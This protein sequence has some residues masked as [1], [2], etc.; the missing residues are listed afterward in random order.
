MATTPG[1][2]PITEPHT[3]QDEAP[4]ET[5]TPAKVASCEVS[6]RDEVEAGKDEHQGD[7]STSSGSSHGITS[8]VPPLAISSTE[9]DSDSKDVKRTPRSRT[10]SLSTPRTPR[11][12]SKED[13]A[14][15]QESLNSLTDL[16]SHLHDDAT[17]DETAPIVSDNE[18]EST[19]TD[20]T[21]EE[22]LTPREDVIDDV[23]TPRDDA[24]VSSM[25]TDKPA[26]KETL[27]PGRKPHEV[28]DDV[29][30]E[31]DKHTSRT[32]SVHNESIQSE[33]LMAA[34]DMYAAELLH[35]QALGLE[36]R[37]PNAP[38]STD[39]THHTSQAVRVSSQITVTEHGPSDHDKSTTDDDSCL[40]ADPNQD[41]VFEVRTLITK[42]HATITSTSD[43]S[44]S[45]VTA[46]NK[47]PVFSSKAYQKPRSGPQSPFKPS[48][49]PFSSGRN[50]PYPAM[51][52]LSATSP[53]PSPL[54]T[55]AA[56][57]TET[58]DYEANLIKELEVFKTQAALMAHTK[59]NLEVSTHAPYIRSSPGLLITWPRKEPGHQQEWF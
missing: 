33:E 39:T 34:I 28:I 51:E 37:S 26:M 42:T 32:S 21:T 8:I 36:P 59:Q 22:A 19:P 46:T 13:S 9:E 27:S 49:S 24:T 18:S 1:S 45:S 44:S 41:E 14:R 31:S 15:F 58:S 38:I 7:V 55:P 30:A 4:L 57:F 53:C 20:N 29:L 50:S 56:M 54:T 10:T 5:S 40:Y 3:S 23:L 35:R 17:D 47:P 16:V 6:P 43:S 25:S 2:P 48:P 12:P 11:T 52:D